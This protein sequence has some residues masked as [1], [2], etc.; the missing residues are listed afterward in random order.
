VRGVRRVAPRRRGLCRVGDGV[1]GTPVGVRRR[2]GTP[3]RSSS[4]RTSG[5][6]SPSTALAALV[7]PAGGAAALVQPG[8]GVL[9]TPD[10]E[11]ALSLS[12]YGPALGRRFRALKAVGG[13]ALANGAAACRRTSAAE[14]SWR[15]P[16]SAGS[17]PSRAGSCAHPG[18]SR[19]SA[20]GSR[21]MT[22]ENRALLE[23]VNAGGEIFISSC[24]LAGRYVLRLAV[25][26]MRTNRGGCAS[27]MGGTEKGSIGA[28]IR[29]VAVLTVAL[30][31][32]LA[33]AARAQAPLP[34][35]S[36]A[37]PPP[38][39]FQG[40][41]ADATPD[42]GESRRRPQPVHGA[43]RRVR[44][45]RRRLAD[46]RQHLG[47][48]GRPVAEDDHVSDSP[49]LRLDHLRPPRPG[50]LDLRGPERPAAV[51]VSTRTRLETLATYAGAYALAPESAS[52]ATPGEK[53]LSVGH[54][55][56]RYFGV[57]N[58]HLFGWALA[59]CYF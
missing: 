9:R 42:P 34:I 48:P 12:E 40:V 6:W 7:P 1:P 35:A 43:E 37:I 45:P 31:A 13:P 53:A 14:S 2:R 56:R 28:V 25:G 41:T 32:A 16:S 27:R 30:C 3:T 44:D 36:V 10:A 38:P 50:G 49:R 11:D 52:H 51:H 47:R 33:A 58:G 19:S 18:G 4:T 59:L 39:P 55:H 17:R 54:P 5:C 21:V 8:A 15:R 57:C 23:R 22:S 29:R 26:Q 46:R 20:S 24:V